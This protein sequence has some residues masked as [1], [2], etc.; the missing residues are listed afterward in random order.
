MDLDLII[1]PIKL[2][3]FSSSDNTTFR[4]ENGILNF[5]QIGGSECEV[6]ISADI[7]E[8]KKFTV[9]L[10]AGTLEFNKNDKKSG[11]ITF[12]RTGCGC[13]M[14]SDERR[15]KNEREVRKIKYD[16][17]NIL[18]LRIFIDVSAVEIFIDEGEKVISSRFY[19]KNVNENKNY[20]IEFKSDGPTCINEIKKYNIVI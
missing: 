1:S 20:A 4:Y 8:T 9:I 10:P 15:E 12:D 19:P 3:S 17:K 6:I 11:Y 18:E 7:S 5:P 16:F 14:R 2:Q 13:D